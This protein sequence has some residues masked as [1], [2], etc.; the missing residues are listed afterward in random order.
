M[1]TKEDIL[2]LLKSS[3]CLV[4]FKKADGTERVMICTLLDTFIDSSS[5]STPGT[6]NPDP[7]LVT[8]WDI[9]A[10]GWRSFKPSRLLEEVVAIKSYQTGR[11]YNGEYTGLL[12]RQ[13]RVQ[14]SGGPP[15]IQLIWLNFRFSTKSVDKKDDL[16]V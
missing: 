9:E 5:Y 11:Q 16:I 14:V 8:V 13:I 12:I 4:M 1:Q 15:I 2:K 10:D 3:M 7:D 6:G